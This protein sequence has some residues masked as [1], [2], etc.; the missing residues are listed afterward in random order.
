MQRKQPFFPFVRKDIALQLVVKRH[1]FNSNKINLQFLFYKSDRLSRLY[2]TIDH[3]R[4]IVCFLSIKEMVQIAAI[5]FR[6][7]KPRKM[8]LL[9]GACCSSQRQ[10]SRLLRQ[11]FIQSIQ[12]TFMIMIN[13]L[14]IEN[15]FAYT[16]WCLDDS[17]VFLLWIYVYFIIR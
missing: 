11:I 7:Y 4:Y 12:K 8:C 15:T 16:F 9:L 14:L 5:T 2:F 17:T 3:T 1:V 13:L 10:S 6:V